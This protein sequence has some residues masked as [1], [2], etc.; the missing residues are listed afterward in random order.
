LSEA[1]DGVVLSLSSPVAE[2]E[3]DNDTMAAASNSMP[4][5]EEELPR[6][7][8][9]VALPVSVV[10]VVVLCRGGEG[11]ILLGHE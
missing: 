2:E 1:L 6:L 7:V 11:L 9:P 3:E 4:V 10:S 8:V 5:A